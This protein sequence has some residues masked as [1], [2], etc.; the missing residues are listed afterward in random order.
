M[1]ILRH[2]STLAY[3]ML[4][5]PF[6]TNAQIG[7]TIWQENFDSLD[8]WIIATGNGSWGWGNGELQYYSENN[9]AIEEIP[10][11]S[12]N[13]TLKI[14]AREE[15]GSNI[16][17][18]WGNPLNY[19]SG[20]INTKSKISVKYG[21]IETRVKVPDL[22]TGGWPAVWMLGTSNFAWPS[23]GEIDIMEMGHQKAFRDLH[24]TH[25]G[26]D[27]QNN[28]TV[29][30]MAGAN[31]IYFSEEAIVPG[32]QSGAASLSWDPDDNFSRPYYSNDNPLNDRFLKYRTYWDESSLR[33]TII[34]NEIE[35]D[36]FETPFS[37]DSTSNEFN[38]PF[39]FL[40]NLA[41]GGAFTDAYHLGDPGSGQPVTMP[42]PA[43]MFVDY[44]RVMKWNGQG[45]VFTG[46]PA[47]EHGTFGV[48]TD[49]TETTNELNIGE[50]AEI[51]VWEGTLSEGSIE[52]LEGENSISWATNNIG[53]FGAGVMSDQPLNLFNFGEGSL[54]FSIKIPQN[55]SFKIGV[56]D[57]WG[58]QHY[59]DF[60]AYEDIYGLVRNGEWGNASIPVSDLR[61]ALIDMRM[62]SYSF[63]ILETNGTNCEFALDDIYYEGG[64]L[65]SEE[66]EENVM[67]PSFSIFPNPVNSLANIQFDLKQS[68]NVNL[69]IYNLHGIRIATL[70]NKS[71]SKG[72][73]RFQWNARQA[74]PG[75][76]FVRLSANDFISSK[77][78]IIR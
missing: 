38:Y 78:L 7:D 67:I 4:L 69:S 42:F 55:V 40:V 5:S 2:L 30:E 13:N 64:T 70:T 19:T 58:N 26:G 33:F 23:K 17:D 18:Q 20:K 54:N 50:N 3:F 36:L 52:P 61:G 51:F 60:P 75:I 68:S 28:S 32:N 66:P 24:D 45:E 16:V 12:G 56:I 37:I 35:Y 76:Y 74:D 72:N 6:L 22:E 47:A 15:S 10:G 63:V 59:I 29:N 41:I 43:D 57:T 44:I 73:H 9:V 49:S 34:D 71:L 11:E 77:K 46:P 31:A 62:L 65:G 25:N 53:W 27:G 39:Y 1:K 14:T 48:Y 8:N 21:V